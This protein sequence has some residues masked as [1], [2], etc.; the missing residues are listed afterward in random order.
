MTDSAAMKLRDLVPDRA[1][2]ESTVKQSLS[3]D[4]N[5]RGAK[6]AW[7]VVGSQATD[8]LKGVLDLDVFELLARAWC[9]AK[10]IHDYKD[11]SKHP[12]GER[13]VVFLGEHAFATSYY[14][15]L[16]V[17]IGSL[18]SVSL[19]FTLALTANI[20]SVALA[21]CDGCITGLGAGDGDLGAQL[22]YAGVTL[23]Q[24]A[25]RKLPFPARVEFKAPGLAIV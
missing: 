2:M 22:A 3:N 19:R 20:R 1:Q 16:T 6:L 13:S 15:T 4:P 24:L 21:I 18:K 11:A 12:T 9:T 25:S 8:A 17:T 14:P 5:A 23:G 10:Q 7:G